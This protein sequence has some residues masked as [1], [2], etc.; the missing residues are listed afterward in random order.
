MSTSGAISLDG[1]QRPNP[2]KLFPSI[3]I[4]SALILVRS[5]FRVVEYLWRKGPWEHSDVYMYVFDAVPM[6]LML[7]YWNFVPTGKFL[8]KSTKVKRVDEEGEELVGGP[9]P[10]A[11]GLNWAP[12]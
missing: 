8:G 9:G 2:Q 3:Y 1:T 7:V 4:A 6:L 10:G 12:R 11:A 5:I